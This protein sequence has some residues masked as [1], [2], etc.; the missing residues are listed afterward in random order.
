MSPNGKKDV[1]NPQTVE[2]FENV[3]QSLRKE[4]CQWRRNT[5]D[6]GSID[7][8]RPPDKSEE[9]LYMTICQIHESRRKGG[10][11]K[12]KKEEEKKKYKKKSA[13]QT[14]LQINVK[15]ITIKFI[16][17][18]FKLVKGMRYTCESR[19]KFTTLRWIKYKL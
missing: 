3:F 5:Y 15:Q 4:S 12:K 14:F 1:T 8:K 6:D 11:R 2:P 18:Y 9:S 10:G 7:T 17:Y 19:R 16:I 13:E